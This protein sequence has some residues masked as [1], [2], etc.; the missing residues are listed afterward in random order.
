MRVNIKKVNKF[1]ALYEEYMKIRPKAEVARL[2]A[3]KRGLNPKDV[4]EIVTMQAQME[5]IIKRGKVEFDVNPH[6]FA[7]Y[8]RM[9]KRMAE[10]V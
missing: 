5:A 9:L 8:G 6:Y 4:P 7:L 3:S 1:L 10:S 2:G